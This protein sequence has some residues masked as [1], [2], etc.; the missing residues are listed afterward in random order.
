[1]II[2]ALGELRCGG[3]VNNKRHVGM[4]LQGGGGNRGSDRAFNGFRNGGGFGLAGGEQEDSPG[5]ED[6]ADSHGDGA[7][8]ALLALGEELGVIV[9]RFLA[10]DLQA[11][12]R[13]D[14]RSRLVETD[15]AVAADTQQLKI[16][17]AG[18]PD[19]VFIRSAILVVIA[20]NG[21]VGN[22]DV[23]GIDVDVGEEVFVHEM[24]KAPGMSS[25]KPQVLIEIEGHDAREI[26]GALFVKT[27]EMFVNADHGAAGGQTKHQRRLLMNRAGDELRGLQ[28]NCFV[29][30]FQDN[31]HA[32]SLQN[33]ALRSA[34]NQHE[35]ANEIHQ[36]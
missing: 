29:V 23:A 16:D 26:E 32:A 19:G 4:E 9:H 30:A 6:G 12:A 15:M 31:Q 27:D 18:F 24:L 3:I 1:M 14:A 36:H 21:S 22:V 7:T 34:R 28:T 2:I 5:L 25:G 33:Q 13:A 11:R 10:Q 17:S 35:A 20:A 8:G